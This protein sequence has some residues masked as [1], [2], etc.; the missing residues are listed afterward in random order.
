MSK[1]SRTSET[2]EVRPAD[3]MEWWA[4]YLADLAPL[5]DA[6]GTELVALIV[7]RL[8]GAIRGGRLKEAD[9]L[10]PE[11]QLSAQL[12]VSRATVREAL[13]ELE[14]K[15]L[16]ERR[17]G[18][19]TAVVD[20]GRGEHTQQLLR[21]L[22]ARERDLAEVMDFRET[23]EVPMAARAARSATKAD[24]ARLESLF[25]RM[26]AEI[27]GERYG[28][29]DERFHLLVARATHNSLLAKVVELT[30]QWTTTSRSP[31]L[32]N[33]ARR[34]LS[35]EGHRAILDGVRRRD[36]ERAAEAMRGHIRQ[37]GEELAKRV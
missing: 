29:L 33:T 17:Q 34:R 3:V 11:R 10:P 16:V 22:D 37:L 9:R 4:S 28:E 6:R 8:E 35:L 24:I 23:I 20:L 32:E 1:S 5:S 19:G 31:L 30:S 13:H 25:E 26:E 2:T 18:R 12:G 36:P 15:G 7:A 21:K 14:L 27:S